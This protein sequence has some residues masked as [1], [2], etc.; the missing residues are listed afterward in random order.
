MASARALLLNPHTMARLLKG[1]S[2]TLRVSLLSVALSVFFGLIFGWIMTK[3][4]PI[5]KIL[6][7]IY[8]EFMRL[9]PQLVL[10][11]IVYF[12]MARALGIHISGFNA[13]II[14]FTLWG[15]AEM[16]DL[17]RGAISSIPKHQ[18]EAAASIGLTRLQTMGYVVLPQALRRLIPQAM[19]LVTRMIKT[20]SLIALI[21]V[22]E[23]IKTGQQIVEAV[24]L[25]FASAALWIYLVIL[26]LYFLVCYPLSKW[27]GHLE[28]KWK[29]A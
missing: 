25:E 24:R 20:T 5:I 19:N 16:G 27:A 6:S 28:E 22:V 23:V 1:L 12:G 15:T 8:L 13:A 14:V 3:K 11:F 29:E 26:I 10:L 21:G 17:V 9:M 7:K 18:Y 2:V 4:S